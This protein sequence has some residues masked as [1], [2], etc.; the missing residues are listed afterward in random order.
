M[1]FL[2]NKI[3]TRIALVYF[4]FGCL[5]ILL[6]DRILVLFLQDPI[7]LTEIQT[8]KGW[9]F[10]AASALLVYLLL[11]HYLQIKRKTDQELR[12]NAERLHLALDAAQQGIYDLNVQT[13]QSIVSDI[14]ATM[15]GYDPQTFEETNQRWI[16]RMHPDDVESV[17]Q[18]YLDYTE[19]KTAEYRVEFRQKTASGEWKWLL[20][21]GKIVEYDQQGHPLRMLGTHTDITESK[22]AALKISQLILSLQDA[23]QELVDAYDATIEGWSKAMDLRDHET[24]GHTLRVTQM[25]MALAQKMGLAEAEI[26]QI[27]RGALLHDIGKMG[28]P[29]NILLK[30]GLLTAEERAIIQR[31]PRY[32]FDM[33]QAIDYLRPALEIPHYHHEKWDGSGYPYGLKATDIPLVARMFAP[34]DVYDAL[35]SDRPYRQA[36]SDQEAMAYIAEQSAKHFDPDLVPIFLDYLKEKSQL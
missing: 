2:W 19:G 28:I 13:G 30:P 1:R 6:S 36:W 27:R 5:W 21:L 8:Y 3:E 10:V 34:I 20:S 11:N 29:D 18:T 12:E 31:H 33:L 23:Q 17:Q 9:F 24:E 14:Y 4:L 26:A 25:S 16:E 32:A 35:T 7:E 15:L 22:N